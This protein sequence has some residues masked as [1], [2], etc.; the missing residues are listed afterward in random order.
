MDDDSPVEA[1]VMVTN[2]TVYD[3]EVFTDAAGVLFRHEPVQVHTTED[4]SVVL[5][6]GTPALS[7]QTTP[8]NPSTGLLGAKTD[9]S[10]SSGSTGHHPD[11]SAPGRCPYGMDNI[12]A[13]MDEVQQEVS[14]Y[15]NMKGSGLDPANTRRLAM[16]CRGLADLLA[17]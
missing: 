2:P 9:S 3:L 6:V 12:D 8:E 5:S 1:F 16:W 11:L 15:R 13:V 14:T 10:G 7:P 4:G 17:K